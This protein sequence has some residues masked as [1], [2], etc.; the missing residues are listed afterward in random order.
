MLETMVDRASYSQENFRLPMTNRIKIMRGEVVAAKPILCSE[1]ALLVT[2]AYRETEGAPMVIRRAEAIREV[3]QNM[4]VRIWDQ[5]LIVGNHGSNGRR[6]APVFPE[7]ATSWLEDELDEGLETRPQ[8]RFIVPEKVK[9]DLKSI[10]P[11]WKGKTVYDRYRA[12]VPEETKR[13]REV[14]MFTRD[15]FE[16]GGYGHAVYDT[17]KVLKVGFKGIKDEIRQRLGKLDETR[18]GDQEMRSFYKALLIT[19]DA[20]ISFA[21]R[22]AEEA[23]RLAAQEINKDRRTELDKI[24]RACAWV[25]ENPARDFWEAA[26]GAWFLQ[27]CVQI[28]TNGNAVSPGR[29]DQYL[30][31]YYK[32]DLE[33]GEL[34]MVEAQELLDCFW[35][36]LNEIIKVWD[37]E[38]THVH[39][40][41]PMTQNLTIGGQTPDGLD[42]T[43]ELSHLMLNSHEHI[44]LQNPQFTVRIWRNTPDDFLMRVVETVRL[45]TGM[46]AMFGDETCIA[47]IIRT[48]GMPLD[49]ARDFRIV[50]CN[51]L[52]P[53]GLQGRANGAYFNVAR[54][55]DLALN[56]GVDRLTGERIG[57]P[58][59]EPSQFGKFD[60]VLD[61]VK[62]QMAYFIR[63]NVINNLVI[64]MAQREITPHVFLS[65]IT[66]G[67]I[68]KGRDITWGGSLYG[69]TP[70][71]GVGMAT[72]ADSLAA[73]KK[74]VFDQKKLTMSELKKA[75]DSNYEGPR[76]EEI[77]KMVLRAPKFGNDDDDADTVARKLYDIFFDEVESHRDIDSRPYTPMILT[78]GVTV[79]HGW[80][81]GATADGRGATTPVSDSMSPTNGADRNGPTAVLKSAS[82]IDMVRMMQGGILNLKF[83]KAAL[84]GDRALRKF[85]HLVRTYLVDLKGIE[86]Q[87][88]VID[89]MTLRDAQK[90][91]E[92]HPDLIIRIAGYSARFVELAREMQDDIIARTEHSMVA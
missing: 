65:S 3:L 11:Y 60:S 12:S 66:E 36:K 18:A 8:D 55:V 24:T 10:F 61:S 83:S 25:P 2:K 85:A 77:R 29:L 44:R 79:P 64:D 47:A 69:V 37:R 46:P 28:E 88:N 81:T 56:D 1:R 15:L 71:Q 54:V 38:A 92:N 87:A 57:P 86:L 5:E 58:T 68:E 51:E 49:R 89:A 14:Y 20:I 53:R 22:F 72:A 23:K 35:L 21:H 16:R 26:Q 80:K 19:S 27:L 74:L 73:V 59:G 45:G 63:L 4:T 67:C 78:L 41:F 39:P 42:A 50:G 75:Q 13:A 31:P 70:I 82:K 52:A 6:S 76:G 48:T 34:T 40:G 32:E 7:W 9:K 33:K 17:P 30:Y 43:N 62:K 84:E 91:P 90:H